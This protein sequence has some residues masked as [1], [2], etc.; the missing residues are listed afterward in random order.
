[1]TSGLLPEGTDRVDGVRRIVPHSRTRTDVFEPCGYRECMSQAQ[2]DLPRAWAEADVAHVLGVLR[3]TGPRLLTELMDD[4]E[5]DGWPSQ[6]LEGAVVSAWSRN[7][8]S[9]TAGDLIVAL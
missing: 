4:E 8:I 1:M 7:V 6:R 3:R 9:I 5:F 2:R